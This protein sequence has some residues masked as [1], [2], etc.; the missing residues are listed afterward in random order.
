MAPCWPTGTIQR[1]RDTARRRR[2]NSMTRVTRAASVA[3]LVTL[4]LAGTAAGHRGQ[5][6]QAPR[7]GQVGGAVTAHYP[8]VFFRE[9]WKFDSSVPNQH[10][11]REPEHTIVQGDVKNPSLEVRLYGDKA[12]TR[13]VIQ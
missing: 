13:T 8:P 1:R 6:P 9:D 3:G 11:P 2:R 7:P 4:C 10:T 5:A 12:G